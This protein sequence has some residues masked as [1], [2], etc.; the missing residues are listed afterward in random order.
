MRRALFA[1]VVLLTI[2]APIVFSC[3]MATVVLRQVTPDLTVVVTHRKQPVAG[4]EV[5]VTPMVEATTTQSAASERP[6]FSGITDERG[7]VRIR[8]LLPGKY[9]LTASH[10]E[11]EAGKAWIEVTRVP[12][13]KTMKRFE[14]EW[15]DWSYE[16]SRVAGKLTGYVPG[17]TGDKLMDIARPVETAYPGVDLTL[18]GAFSDVESHTISDSTGAFLFG[19]VP[20]GIYLLT[21]AGGMK[22]VTGTAGVTT[23]VVDVKRTSRRDSL[24]LQLKNTG[25]YSTQFELSQQ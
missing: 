4:I 24:P 14:F 22:S 25:C 19:E 21:I 3:S 11:F 15:A 17:N 5:E 16:T 9:W 13:A 8:G 6:L 10:H 7:T 18:K 20:D 2:A 23:L 12:N 1:L